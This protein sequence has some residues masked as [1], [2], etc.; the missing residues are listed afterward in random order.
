[1]PKTAVCSQ[2]VPRPQSDPRPQSGPRPKRLLAP[3]KSTTGKVQW[4]GIITLGAIAFLAA[5]APLFTPFTPTEMA[6]APFAPPS[7]AHILGCDD[8]G[9][10]LWSQL[11]FGGRVSLFV[12][13][14]VAFFATST[15]VLLAVIAGFY[16]GWI[17]RFLMRVVDVA[18]SLPFLPLVIV[19]G[20]FFGAS[21]A[22]QILV[23]A[24]VMWAGPVR[25]LRAQILSIRHM[26]YVEAAETMGA[27]ARHIGRRHLLPEIAP[28]IVPQFVRIAHNAVLVE[29][30][31]S[32]LG[33]GDP[34]QTSWGTI[35]F[36]ANARAAFLTG[37]WVWWIV[38]AGVAVSLTVTALAF[39]GFGYDAAL[40]PRKPRKLPQRR[41]AQTPLATGQALSI[42]DLSLSFYN[43]TAE[44]KVLHSVSLDLGRGEL[45]GLVGESGSGKT[46]L[47]LA[48][49]GLLR[50]TAHITNGSI[51]ATGH[52]VLDLAPHRMRGL[53]GRKFALIPQSAMNALNPVMR[54]ADQ[55]GEALAN[56]GQSRDQIPVWLGHVGLS[57][58]DGARYPHEMSGGMRQRAVIAIA[59]CNTPDLVIADEPTTG[60]DVLVQEEIMQLLL[61]LRQRLG[62]SILFVT[63]NLPL[64]ARHADRLAVMYRGEIVESGA[65]ERLQSHATHPHTKALFEALPRRDA[66]KLWPNPCAKGTPVLRVER[67]GKRYQ[68]TSIFGL[69]KG[70]P[71]TA[72]HPISFDLHAGETLGI[73]GGSGAG[74]ST[75]ARLLMG[76]EPPS[77][78]GIL[79]PDNRALHPA[80]HAHGNG[81][82]NGYR[83]IQMVFQDPF[84]AMRN[85]MT[86]ADVVAEPLVVLGDTAKRATRI[87]DALEA[88]HL[89]SDAAFQNRLPIQLSGGQR[90]RLAFARAMITR[91]RI[92]IADE[93]TSMLD[94]SLRMG[95]LAVM[96]ALRRSHGTAFIFITHDILLARHFC[97]RV[98][99][100]RHGDIVEHGE[101]EQVLRQPDHPYTKQLIE[102]A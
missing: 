49:L 79:R 3:I 98:V 95:I 34:L 59:L 92:I 46:T 80:K 18:L 20:V 11:L 94:Q 77:E 76:L 83:D 54:I 57:A 86:V 65:P 96:D 29:T 43:D 47:A 24:L 73:V 16:G 89:P 38:P 69:A 90:Q 100:L 74:K 28:L 22:T 64:I 62:L 8:A 5:C 14:S 71:F 87:Q 17:D 32:F 31:L 56:G 39:I 99:V 1:M 84:G 85:A 6:C 10:D 42:R 68:P 40:S 12:G 48:S 26:G 72:L 41:P 2:T 97:D 58:A 101:A 27:S 50:D 93:P 9:H 25:E 13:I 44:T 102:V 75:L 23:I 55:L 45:L 53:R 82:K 21:L 67:L 88:V 60:L 15:A 33:L 19:L 52:A 61:K 63:H 51:L 66:P 7:R 78:G 91:P 81:P 36:H 4:V 35:L 37:S 30:S 70:A